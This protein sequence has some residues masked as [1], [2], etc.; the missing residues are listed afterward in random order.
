M[1]SSTDSKFMK[2]YGNYKTLKKVS[3]KELFKHLGFYQN[4]PNDPYDFWG[5]HYHFSF[6]NVFEDA[7][8]ILEP[9]YPQE[10]YPYYYSDKDYYIVKSPFAKAKTR[11]TLQLHLILRAFTI[12]FLKSSR[13]KKTLNTFIDELSFHSK[14]QEIDKFRMQEFGKIFLNSK[15]LRLGTFYNIVAR[16]IT[17]K[18]IRKA[19]PISI[20]NTLKDFNST[21]DRKTFKNIMMFLEKLDIQEAKELLLKPHFI[22]TDKGKRYSYSGRSFNL[23]DSLISYN[24]YLDRNGNLKIDKKSIRTLKKNTSKAQK[25][26]HKH[27][28]IDES[29]KPKMT[30][31]KQE[32]NPTPKQNTHNYIKQIATKEFWSNKEIEDFAKKNGYMKMKFV[33]EI[34]KYC[35]E[36]YNDFLL[37]DCEN[38]FEVNKHIVRGLNVG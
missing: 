26:L 9:T 6:R 2:R 22:V 3:A 16:N 34:N 15:D 11:N 23:K 32:E 38:G 19:L 14:M 12:I 4:N 28:K 33:L 5:Y 31:R 36:Q 18:K 30:K 37:I 27:I 24:P 25:V 10:I 8:F 13:D 1:I 20:V 7:G 29:Q 35:D 17:S 21:I